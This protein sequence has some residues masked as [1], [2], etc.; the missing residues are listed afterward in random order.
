MAV[1][2]NESGYLLVK[3][4]ESALILKIYQIVLTQFT[5]VLRDI[6]RGLMVFAGYILESRSQRNSCIRP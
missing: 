5:R 3:S 4:V 2:G 6:K 1:S